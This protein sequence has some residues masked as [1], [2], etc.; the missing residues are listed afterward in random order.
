MNKKA[1]TMNK[2]ARL[3]LSKIWFLLISFSIINTGGDQLG[4]PERPS[5]PA[6]E[7]QFRDSYLDSTSVPETDIHMVEAE[8]A[9]INTREEFES[10][11]DLTVYEIVT[12]YRD[13]SIIPTNNY[14]RIFLQLQYG[15][16]INATNGEVVINLSQFVV[17]NESD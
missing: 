16:I 13:N 9:D 2:I 17:R 14:Q 6:L 12:E 10:L 11:E 7:E 1:P 4:T 5:E 8:V 15:Q 3:L